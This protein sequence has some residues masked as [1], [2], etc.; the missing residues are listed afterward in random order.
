MGKGLLSI[1]PNR[2]GRIT[3]DR[4]SVE[5]VGNDVVAKFD[6]HTLE[7]VRSLGVPASFKN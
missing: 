4:L 2:E 5:I 1:K 3:A 6:G 7:L